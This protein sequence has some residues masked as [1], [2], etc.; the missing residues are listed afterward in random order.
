MCT[1]SQLKKIYIYI[2][3]TLSYVTRLYASIGIDISNCI[4]VG[5]MKLPTLVDY[6]YILLI[7]DAFLCNECIFFNQ[8]FFKSII[9]I[10]IFF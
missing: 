4:E 7:S 8:F 1:Y 2:Y 5:C 6:T 10:I 3:V 9:I